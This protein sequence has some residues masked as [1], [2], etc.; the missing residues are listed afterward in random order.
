[1]LAEI[2]AAA[3]ALA[4]PPVSV[5]VFGSFARGDAG[6]DS[7][8]DVVFVRPGDVDEDDERWAASMEEWRTQVQA[9]TGNRVEVLEVGLDEA[10][11]R[12]RSTRQVWRDIRRDGRVVHG[13]RLNELAGVR[14]A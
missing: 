7:D 3:A 11:S 10:S 4:A 5:I 9:I 8:L 6:R 12:L 13:L 1:V 2:G 14:S